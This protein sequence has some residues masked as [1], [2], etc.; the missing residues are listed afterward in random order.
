MT[1]VSIGDAG[2]SL[3]ALV[4]RLQWGPVLIQD[5][6]QNAAVLISPEDY[7]AL[8]AL[9]VKELMALTEESGR[10]AESQGMTDEL[11]ERLLA[12]E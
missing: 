3:N 1:T 2:Q 8:R 10:Y 12:E 5:N 11:L 7:E 6:G 9:R 4:Q